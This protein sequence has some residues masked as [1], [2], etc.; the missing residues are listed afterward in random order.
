MRISDLATELKIT[1]D[2]I[3]AKLKTLK[4]K[5][6][7]EALELNAVVE[8]VLRDEF[9]KEG[10]VSSKKRADLDD[11]DDGKKKSKSSKAGKAAPEAAKKSK[12]AKGK[13]E[14]TTKKT[15]AKEKSAKE[16]AVSSKA[17]KVKTKDVE[18][19]EPE[20]KIQ[21]SKP[22]TENISPSPGF[23]SLQKIRQQIKDQNCNVFS[24]AKII[25]EEALQ[26]A[27]ALLLEKLKTKSNNAAVTNNLKGAE[28]KIIDNN[29]IE[30]ITETDIQKAFVETQRADLVEHLQ[31]YF[32][33]RALTYLVT[34]TE[35]EHIIKPEEMTL[36]RKQQYLKIIEEY[37]LVKELKERL[38]L[39]LE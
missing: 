1:Q 13:D 25:T 31:T 17:D 24:E 19:Q 35:K 16:K 11:D 18:I 10:I 14:K 28:L 30:I 20:V 21:S 27:W 6:K 37:P 2:K 32:N 39:E 8:I 9:A 22:K 3:L 15:K 33:N 29:C 12:D 7:G 5:A 34:V 4:L 38:K 36:S 23:S 26:S